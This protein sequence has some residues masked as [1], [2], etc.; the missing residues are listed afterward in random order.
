MTS[1][2]STILGLWHKSHDKITKFSLMIISK[3]AD[4][5]CDVCVI[6]EVL[7][8]YW[9]QLVVLHYSMSC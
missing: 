3:R 2:T 9:P 8:N 1:A 7:E 4:R 6:S 5:S